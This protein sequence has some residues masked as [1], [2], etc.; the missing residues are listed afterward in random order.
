MNFGKL[1]FRIY[2]IHEVLN[3]SYK[4]KLENQLDSPGTISPMSFL[5][6]MLL[7]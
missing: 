1:K 7:V 4:G 6:S 3:Y 5:S 2:T